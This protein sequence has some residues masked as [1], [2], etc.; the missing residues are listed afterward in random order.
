MIRDVAAPGGARLRPGRGAYLRRDN[1]H[2]VPPERGLGEDQL[3]ERLG[4]LERA[5]HEF[6]DE[7]VGAAERH[8]PLDQPL[9]EV[10]GEQ[11]RIGGG[12]AH[13]LLVELDRVDEPA[14]GAQG[15][16]DLFERVEERLLVL[17]Q[18]T[19]VG[20]RQALQ[21]REEP[22]KVADQPA[23]LGPR[24]LGDVGVL[25]LGQHRAPR[26]P[27]IV[28]PVEAELDRREN[29]E[30]LTEAGEVHA[31]EGEVEK[32]LGDEVAVGDGVERVLEA[33]GK[34]ELA[35]DPVGVEEQRGAGERAGAE[36]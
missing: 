35:G 4:F 36:R 7:P 20:E 24:E 29:D 33:P 32:R 27:G 18:V 16:G 15:A 23:G 28:E 5:A 8:P 30:L 2:G 21:G 22:G 11:R 19:V 3:G 10:D 6:P 34:T 12:P 9:G 25:L 13:R 31:D 17:L 14:Y 26:R 1:R